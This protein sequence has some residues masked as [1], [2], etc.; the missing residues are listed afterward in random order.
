MFWAHSTPKGAKV[1][2]WDSWQQVKKSGGSPTELENMP[3]LPEECEPA[4]EA[5]SALGQDIKA[6][7]IQAYIE[8]TGH[9]LD[10]WEVDAIL[11]L[12]QWR[13]VNWQQNMQS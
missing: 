10:A 3:V 7:D 1:S 5:F 13:S 6:S 12:Q 11:A 8:L 9:E 4:W 2:R